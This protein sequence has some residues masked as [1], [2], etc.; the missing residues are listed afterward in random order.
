MTTRKRTLAALAAGAL[1]V[2]LMGS[3]ASAAPGDDT[4]PPFQPYTEFC[5]NVPDDQGDFQ[6]I[7][8]NTHEEA[9]RCA[10]YLGIALGGPEELTDE[11]YGPRRDVRRD[12]MASFIAR[13][14]D[15]A[16]DLD[17]DG[18]I[19]E[20]GAGPATQQFQDVA[21]QQPQ[22]ANSNT[23]Y[24]NVQR[25]AGEEIVL[26]GPGELTDD[27]YGPARDVQRD[28]MASFIR[29]SA[30]FMIGQWPTSDKDYYVDDEE[31]IHEDN[32]NTVTEARIAQGFDA[33]TYGPYLS[34]PRDQ[35]A[36]FIVRTLAVLHANGLI[37]AAGEDCPDPTP[38][39]TPTPT[40]GAEA[41]GG[42][43]GFVARLFG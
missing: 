7:D 9:I 36:A 23:H 42:I 3:T 6:D 2:P 30:E 18:N 15:A 31:S 17:C 1:C 32:I 40:D 13:M 14:I 26:G 41:A 8:G 39:P 27:F 43:G 22:T 20:L 11:F 38:T 21:P 28:Q 12:Q 35:M 33:N 24:T 16:N 34:V 5:A 25:L 29:R 37:N 10:N 4:P 19:N